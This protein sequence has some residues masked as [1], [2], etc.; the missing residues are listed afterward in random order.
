M[1]TLK[2]KPYTSL[3]NQ[4]FLDNVIIEIDKESFENVDFVEGKITL[5]ISNCD[6]KSIEIRNNENLDFDD[7]VICFN[8][9]YIECLYT[10]STS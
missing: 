3:E 9:C 8:T 6:F 10:T 7:V 1:T 4:K 2:I 5:P